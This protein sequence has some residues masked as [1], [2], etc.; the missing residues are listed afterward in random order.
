MT[1]HW[2][3]DYI[4][5]PW[6]AR[7]HDCWAFF[8]KVQAAH[9]GNQVPDFGFDPT[10]ALSC[11]RAIESNPET[12]RWQAV[13]VPH[14]GDAVLMGRNRVASHIGVWVSADGGGVLHCLRSS[15][16]VLQKHSR[17]AGDGWSHVQFYRR[18]A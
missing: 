15:G 2:A 9:F 12:G 8:R 17:L 5:Q 6:I 14:E 16:V 3:I 1:T 18:S 7:E 10:V 13:T 4:G 11:A